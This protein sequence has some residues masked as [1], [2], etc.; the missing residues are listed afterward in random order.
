MSLFYTSKLCN[1]KPHD[2][3]AYKV[4]A[5]LAFIALQL[6]II[7][8]QAQP[9]IQTL[10]D[11][12]YHLCS[13]PPTSERLSEEEL[14]VKLEQF[15]AICFHFRKQVNTIVGELYTPGNYGEDIICI[16]GIINQNSVNGRA[17]AHFSYGV[18]YAQAN[19]KESIESIKQYWSQKR[20]LSITDASYFD[21][22]DIPYA[23]YQSA[24]LNLNGF[25]RYNIGAELPP[26]SCLDKTK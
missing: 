4:I 13:L 25:Y 24:L 3:T 5:G 23:I 12:N 17:V 21:E 8:A 19:P 15:D 20:V 14:S 7:P 18:E 6:P 10:S 26:Q 2:N 11:G 1:K 9:I 16:E 22:S